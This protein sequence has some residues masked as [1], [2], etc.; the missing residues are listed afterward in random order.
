MVGLFKHVMPAHCCQ[1]HIKYKVMTTAPWRVQ[2]GC[3]LAETNLH[4]NHAL[5]VAVVLTA[6]R[7]RTLHLAATQQPRIPLRRL[8]PCLTCSCQW[9]CCSCS[10]GCWHTAAWWG[11][12]YSSRATGEITFVPFRNNCTLSCLCKLW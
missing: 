8:P 10:Q 4:S 2:T 1:H 9:P 12:G 5:A 11:R 3:T 7:T 6:G